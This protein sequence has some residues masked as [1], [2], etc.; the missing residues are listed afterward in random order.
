MMHPNIDGIRP[1]R[2]GWIAVACELDS[3]QW[4]RAPEAAEISGVDA[5][6]LR[7]LVKSGL[8][9]AIQRKPREH[10]SYLLAEMYLISRITKDVDGCEKVARLQEM[11]FRAL[12]S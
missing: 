2:W 5:G 3:D 10:Y 12:E 7:R 4:L 9:T 1:L 6:A 11:L 8:V